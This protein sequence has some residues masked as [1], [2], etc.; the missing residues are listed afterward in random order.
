MQ[1]S[2]DAQTYFNQNFD[3]SSTVSYYV[4][5]TNPST[6][7]FNAI[8]TSTGTTVSINNGTLQF[9]R[10]GG[11]G[12]AVRSTN[13]TGSPT[14]LIVT[15]N[16]TVTGNNSAN[17]PVCSR[18]AIGSGFTSAL[19]NE[20]NA[21]TFSYIDIEP[22]SGTNFRIKSASGS[23]SSNF[24]SGTTVAVTW[25]LNRSGSQITYTGPNGSA[26]TLNNNLNDVW[27]GTTRFSSGTAVTTSGVN[28]N[29][30]KF[31]FTSE[32]LTIQI[33][34]L[35]I[36]AIPAV[37]TTHPVSQTVC[38]LSPVNFTSAGLNQT[39][40]QWQKQSS[41]VWG[42]IAGATSA[43]YSIASADVPHIGNY[44]VLY[45][46]GTDTTFSNVATL[47][48]DVPS[49]GGEVTPV[50]TNVC[51]G[52]N[53]GTL[54]LV[55]HETL[56]QKWQFSTNSGGLWTDIAN[57]TNTLNYSNLTTTTWYR[58]VVVNGTCP[59]D[60]SDHAEVVVYPALTQFSI[61]G[62]NYICQ[63]SSG[64][65]LGLN[66]SQTGVNYQLRRNGVNQG[67]AVSGTGSAISFGIQNLAGTYTVNAIHA[68]IG[69]VVQ[70]GASHELQL[71]PVPTLNSV[72][73]TPGSICPGQSS[74]LSSSGT[75][76][77]FPLTTFENNVGG[78]IPNQ[79]PTG[80]DR[81]IIVSGAPSDMSLVTNLSVK[82]NVTHPRTR[83]IELYLTRPGGTALSTT[84]TGNYYNT[85]TPGHNICLIAD[86]EGASRANLT[87]I[88]FSDNGA[89]LSGDNP[90]TGVFKPENL[91]STLTGNPNGT[92][93]LRAVDD[94]SAG[95]I[96]TL[97]DWSITMNLVTGLTYTWTSSPAGFTSNV[98][99]PG[100][101]FPTVTT[102][103]T[104]SIAN[105]VTGCS[106]QGNATVNVS[107]VSGNCSVISHVS[108][109]GGND[110]S[111]NIVGTGGVAPYTVSGNPTSGLSAGTY[112]Y[113][114]TD[115]IGCTGTCSVTITQPA[116]PVSI[117]CSLVNDVTCN[118]G[119][120]GA[121]SVSASG[122]TGAISIS[123]STFT[124]LSAGTHTFTATDANGCT[125][126]CNVII[127]E[128]QP[129]V[130]TCTVIK[131]VTCNGTSDG[132]VSVSASGGTGALTLTSSTPTTN[133][134]GGSYT[135]VFTDANGC[136]GSCTVTINEPAILQA[137][138]SVSKNV[139]CLGGSDGEVSINPTGGTPPYTIT[140]DPLTGLSAG[141]YNYLV[142]G[143]NG[144]T[145][146]CTVTITE[147][148][149]AVSATCTFVND[150]SCF[151]GSDGSANV[152][153][154]GGTPPYTFSPTPSNLTAGIHTIT[155]TDDNGCT[156]TCDVTIG[157]PTQ[158]VPNCSVL[159][160]V[161]CHG[162]SD[163]SVSVSGTGGT[164]NITVS[165]P[166]LSGLSA[167]S[168]TYTLTDENGCTAECTL[169]I[170]EPTPVVANCSVIQHVS[171]N[172]GNDGSVSVTGSGGVGPY[173]IGGDPLT[174]L[175]AG[176][177]NYTVTDAS[178]C[179]ANCSVTITE[180][181]Q[182]TS[183]CSV[184]QHVSCN[185]G[186]D[187]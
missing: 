57:T 119:S 136:T 166:A 168:Y 46:K 39:S 41:G 15:Y 159:T 129:V 4:H 132:E 170:T 142:T 71:V 83:D 89:V 18:L 29:N 148:A 63:G 150:A 113:T 100:A 94:A 64:T 124:G 125:A 169:I 134:S 60:N 106:V 182:L 14:A 131:H 116:S 53:S 72:S 171:C 104:V 165:G 126:T 120:D 180:P 44:R 99:N 158:I 115:A 62:S 36:T 162:G 3:T 75:S 102:T 140:G 161:T 138:C 109:I 157:Q 167:G 82:V 9:A 107:N 153:G 12:I 108:C 114:I 146:T 67:S 163:G 86:K 184:I 156:A 123:P 2:A 78:A 65:A 19:T 7:Q 177:Y 76:N 154:S 164:G 187:G 45:I 90:Y 130:V 84:A 117:S 111:V 26:S 101:V 6:A 149:S 43:N 103:Y 5:A 137:N 20:A 37:I 97:D 66:G 178:G 152:V 92:W 80:L 87:D 127:S 42:N 27:L 61:T 58:A 81:S 110:G 59:A 118:G 147:P 77:Y 79:V 174:G 11:A 141:T 128:P 32:N 50:S 23:N 68:T 185:G 133:L 49:F 10:T 98:Q 31:S 34:N 172:G 181:T 52:V 21:S 135:Y 176:T 173:T 179:V 175:S 40:I 69:C 1:K 33:D 25:V 112:N 85:I 144:C 13:F 74:S 70:M 22:R 95:D 93:T 47:N 143:S 38:Y 121:V 160:H 24:S 73:A 96:G 186:S 51:S 183:V 8:S 91:F 30:I 54:T 55:N 48:L 88:V 56:I 139:S 28:L 17:L 16:L 35:K 151:G 145:A 122:G 155:V 105:A